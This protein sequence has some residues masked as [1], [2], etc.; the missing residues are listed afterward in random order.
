VLVDGPTFAAP[1]TRKFL[2]SLKLLASTTDKAEG[3]K[4]AL[5][6]VLRRVEGALEAVGGK[7]AM[8]TTL[9][10][11]PL[12]HPLSDTF[13]SQTPFRFGAFVAKF[14]LAPSS[15]N[16]TQLSGAKFTLAGRP[17]ALRE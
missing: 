16:L 3:A 13:F 14:S 12:T 7:S 4:K 11:H 2:S 10:G 8:L 15:T 17:D 5:S 9:G 6:S 1:S